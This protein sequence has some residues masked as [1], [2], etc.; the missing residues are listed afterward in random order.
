MSTFTVPPGDAGALRRVVSTVSTLSSTVGETRTDRLRTLGARAQAA[1]PSGRVAAFAGAQGDATKATN[2]IGLSLVTVGGAIADWAAALEDAQ[3]TVRDASSRHTHAQ[4]LWRRARSTGEQELEQQYHQDMR[5]ETTTAERAHGTLDETRRRVLTTLRGEVDLWVPDAPG[6]LQPVQAWQRAAVGAAPTA[7]TLNPQDLWD[8][9]KNPDTQ[10]AKDVVTKAIKGATKG[11]QVYGVLNYVR[12]PSLAAKAESKFLE[13]RNVYQALKGSAPDLSDPKVYKAYLK[14]ERGLLKAYVSNNPAEVRQAQWLF[15]RSRGLLGDMRALE[16]AR[17][18]HPG[19]STPEILGKAGR[20]D[21]LMRPVRAVTP[22]LSK[23]LGPL[24]V[25]GGAYDMYTAVTDPDLET[26]D[27][28]ARFVGGTA[29][30]VGGAVTTAMAFGVIATGPVGLTVVA[31]AGVVA[32]GC[33]AYENREAIAEGAKK[34][35]STVTDGAKKLGDAVA[36]GAKKVW[37]GLFG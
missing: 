10:L 16:N 13:A 24:G 32:V 34:I 37:K 18:F 28:A 20:F 29:T 26:D 7:F 14:A 8:A 1:L 30:A 33:W 17:R 2:A 22:L 27:R 15:K 21:R 19:L 11:Y 31:V 5:D 23:V 3:Q 36:D 9:Y 25:V 4:T 6:S 35:A 12:A